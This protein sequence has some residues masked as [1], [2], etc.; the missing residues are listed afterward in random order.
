MQVRFWIKSI[1]D[2]RAKFA[3]TP[4]RLGS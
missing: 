2:T 3:R 4:R 1:D